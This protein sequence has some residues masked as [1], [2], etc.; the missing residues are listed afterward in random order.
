MFSPDSGQ[1]VIYAG[2]GPVTVA[3]KAGKITSKLTYVDD[4]EQV[5]KPVNI[6]SHSTI[7]VK[8]IGPMMQIKECEA[9]TNLSK[10]A[11][12]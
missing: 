6:E 3:N 5:M 8:N 11:L 9:I 12:K 1:N 4:G 2:I 10:V 7:I